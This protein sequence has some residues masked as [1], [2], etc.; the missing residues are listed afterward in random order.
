M[1]A[2]EDLANFVVSRG[3]RD[4]PSKL[5]DKILVHVIDTLA[6]GVAGA[7]TDTAARVQ[8]VYE[9]GAA[10]G[11][12]IWGAGRASA[13]GAA[14]VNGVAAHMLEID[15][16]GGCDHSGAV[17][18][19]AALAAVEAEAPETTIEELLCAIALGYEVARRVQF[20]LG[21]YPS[22]NSH[23]W[24][25]TSVCG[26]IGAA[27]AVAKILKL[28]TEQ[29]ANA[30]GIASSMMAGTWSFKEGGGEN[31]S[32]HAG[33]PAAHGVESALLANA[34]LAGTRS[35]FSD[36]WGGIGRVYAGSNANP[37]ELTDK[38]GERWVAN[39]ASIKPFPTC[40]S[41]HRMIQ[42]AEAA[43]APRQFAPEQID[44]VTVRVGRLVA[45]MCGE[46]D[47]QVL[48]SLKQRQLSIP[49]GIALVLTTGSM[50]FD[51]LSYSPSHFEGL[52]NVLEKVE[53]HV[54][55]TIKGGHGEGEIIVAL[56]GEEFRFSTEA[57][58]DPR[59]NVTT[60]SGVLVKVESVLKMANR[61]EYLDAITSFATA[62]RDT[63]AASLASALWLN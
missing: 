34:G 61:E 54:D 51:S 46:R 36:T 56:D 29:T 26:P 3:P 60:V 43:V 62:A 2:I 7:A 48:H 57:V 35:A 52:Q 40:A 8:K 44:R 23:G 27:V 24:H 22:V 49:Y 55:D 53:I 14:L 21:G 42:L 39:D 17:V 16:T 18:I 1:T 15:D 6:A 37:A 32:L 33:L 11:S 10:G 59:Y 58:G 38:L 31:K 12:S 50:A 63:P 4:I 28:S 41:S 30:I 13:R 20:F 45:D 25:S 19:P 5:Q 9:T 47:Y